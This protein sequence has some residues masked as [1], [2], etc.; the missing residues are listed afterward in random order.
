MRCIFIYLFPLFFFFFSCNGAQDPHQLA[1][2]KD[3]HAQE[4]ESLKQALTQALRD[5]SELE[6]ICVEL[7]IPSSFCESQPTPKSA[8]EAQAESKDLQ[9]PSAYGAGSADLAQCEGGGSFC[10]WEFDQAHPSGL[11]TATA[12]VPNS[13]PISGNA[14]SADRDLKREL[15]EAKH[16]NAKLLLVLQKEQQA[17]R[18]AIEEL[19]VRQE[20]GR[21]RENGRVLDWSRMLQNCAQTDSVGPRIAAVTHMDDN[22]I[23]YSM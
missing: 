12:E 14:G 10:S 4:T 17:A 23:S 8:D 11:L 15:D 1:V 20:G 16:E 21:L 5:K 22:S 2:L 9:G 18:W 19:Q 13:K 3:H 7:M 6:E